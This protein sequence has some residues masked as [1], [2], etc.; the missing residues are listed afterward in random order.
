MFQQYVFSCAVFKLSSVNRELFLRKELKTVVIQTLLVNLWVEKCFPLV[1]ILLFT[2][3]SGKLWFWFI[4]GQ[5][6]RWTYRNILPHVSCFWDNII[7]AFMFAPISSKLLVDKSWGLLL[8]IHLWWRKDQFISSQFSGNWKS[9]AH[10]LSAL[11]STFYL[12]IF[13]F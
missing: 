1:P 8:F 10:G 6:F 4:H 12:F 2:G 11:L 7:H 9:W 3:V 5:G 13:K